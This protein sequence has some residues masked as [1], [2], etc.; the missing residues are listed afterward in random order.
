MTTC[1]Q[2]PL[3][4][5]ARGDFFK[6]KIANSLLRF[7]NI[8]PVYRREEGKDL[9]YK[10]AETFAD[11]IELFKKNGAVIIF[12]EGLSENKW[13][14]RPLRKGTARLAFEAWNNSDIGEKLKVV[15]VAIHY[16]SW[17]K[18]HPVVYVDFLPG[19]EKTHF[20]DSDE[21]G[22]FNKKFNDL[23]RAILTGRC[24]NLDKST[25]IVSQNKLTGFMLKNYIDGAWSAK[26]LQNKYSSSKEPEFK[27]NYK[28]LADFLIKE[29]INYDLKFTSS[30]M[31]VINL[32]GWMIVFPVAW[33]SNFIPYY[34]CKAI[35]WKSTGGNDF[36]DS[37]FYCMLLITYPIYLWGLFL[38][39][40]HFKDFIAGLIV[41]FLVV[42]SAY[43]YEASKRYILCYFKRKQLIEVK[44]MFRKLFEK[45]ND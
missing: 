34:F 43:Y 20:S 3:H 42:F 24:I 15:P 35:V 12:S 19:I 4:Y 32:I 39:I 18:I 30:I 6:S 27:L 5:T 37:L 45:G 41:L 7:I 2:R 13:E 21:S 22:L 29:N 23:L 31:N 16:C 36:H 25:D 9:M 8:L 44:A 10:N 38:T 28:V 26:K 1:V 40:A 33:L 11:C 17:L 14:L